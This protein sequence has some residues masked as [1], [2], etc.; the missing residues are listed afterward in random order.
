M[1]TYDVTHRFER[2][3]KKMTTEQ[4][5]A[6]QEAVQKFVHDLKQGKGFRKGLRV[7]AVQGAP[8]IFEMTCAD[9]GRATFQYGDAVRAGA[10]HVIWRR[11]GT[12]DV[13]SEP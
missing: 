11:C 1:P 2:D 3:Y 8:G 13:F 6:F 5:R 4:K 12:H 10:V 7:K 9:N